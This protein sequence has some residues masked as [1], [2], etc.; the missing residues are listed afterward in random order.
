MDENYEWTFL[1]MPTWW[2]SLLTILT[3]ISLVPGRWRICDAGPG[4]PQ[5]SAAILFNCVHDSLDVVVVITFALLKGLF[6]HKDAS[7]ALVLWLTVYTGL[8]VTCI[9]YPGV[10]TRD[11]WQLGR[12]KGTRSAHGGYFWYFEGGE[13]SLIWKNMTCDGYRQGGHRVS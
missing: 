6:T 13:G 10:I 9:H 3:G 12:R 4:N 5:K 2:I 1:H 11:G 8:L 7:P